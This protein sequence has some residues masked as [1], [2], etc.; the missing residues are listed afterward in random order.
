MGDQKNKKTTKKTR[1]RATTRKKKPQLETSTATSTGTAAGEG[2]SRPRPKPKPTWKSKP[3]DGEVDQEKVLEAAK[4]LSSLRDSSKPDSRG[5]ALDIDSGSEG[6]GHEDEESEIEIVED[7]DSVDEEEEDEDEDEEEDELD[8]GANREPQ[9]KMDDIMDDIFEQVIDGKSRAKSK[10]RASQDKPKNASSPAPFSIPFQVPV[11]GMMKEVQLASKASWNDAR[12]AF[13]E[14]MVRQPSS[15]RLGYT[16]SFNDKSGKKQTPMSLENEDEWR[17]LKQHVK[18]YIESEQLKNRNK[19]PTRGISYVVTIYLIDDG[20]AMSKA[21]AQAR[22][23][24][25]KAKGSSR[26]TTI[27]N[28]KDDVAE[29][30]E[31]DMSLRETIGK[32]CS[33]HHCSSCMRACKVFPPKIHHPFTLTELSTWAKMIELD[34]AT[35]DQVPEGLIKKTPSSH[36][37]LP[38]QTSISDADPGPDLPAPAPDLPHP[39]HPAPAL[40]ALAYPSPY[41]YPPPPALAPAI[42]PGYP[43]VP[44]YPSA[45]PGYPYPYSVAPAPIPGHWPQTPHR[46]SSSRHVHTPSTY[47]RHSSHKRHRGSSPDFSSD[48]DTRLVDIEYPVMHEWLQSLDEHPTRGRDGQQ[49]T[50]WAERL[51]EESINRLDDL[52][53]STMSVERL[54]QMTGMPQGTA[55]RLKEWAHIDQG[56]LQRRYG[57]R[58]RH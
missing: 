21:Q 17:S 46:H 25:G 52:T 11:G 14:K 40:P 58:H 33:R 19:G 3:E 34:M 2:S 43:P 48:D 50:R 47:S 26:G 27:P 6:D 37:K 7:E 42:P 41:A 31:G 16:F 22:G 1:K 10:A 45:Y 51:Y 15:L 4:A 54:C 38:E 9:T 56:I 36:K 55:A 57:K 12:I 49:Y 18:A 29:D 23:S 28:P 5:V 35:T 32:I 20:V 44:G 24:A 8:E 53:R 39:T 30:T 13:G